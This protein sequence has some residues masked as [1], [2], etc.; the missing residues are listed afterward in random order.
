MATSKELRRNNFQVFIERIAKV[1]TA[2]CVK[3]F[4]KGF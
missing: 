1:V 4:Q 2:L 3:T